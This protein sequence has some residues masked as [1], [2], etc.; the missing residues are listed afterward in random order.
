[1]KIIYTCYGGAHSS[2]LAAAIHL[3]RLQGGPLPTPEAIKNTM[4]FDLVDGS[5]QGRIFPVGVDESGN[6]I[7]TLGRGSHAGAIEQAVRSGFTLAGADPSRLVF[8]NTLPTVNWP[9]RIGGFLSRRLGWVAVG[10]PLVI[11]GA[12]RAYPAL[13]RLVNDVKSRYALPRQSTT[14]PSFLGQE[15]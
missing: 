15:E 9:M 8:V 6:E 10:R 4:Y 14:L 12:L 11:W 1:M 13:V 2:P 7:Y 5:D 3:E